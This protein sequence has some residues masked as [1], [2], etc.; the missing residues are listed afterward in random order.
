MELIRKDNRLK[1]ILPMFLACLLLLASIATTHASTV[2]GASSTSFSMSHGKA[3]L[4]GVTWSKWKST[5][6]NTAYCLE[7]GLKWS[8]NNN[9]FTEVGAIN[10]DRVRF[11]LTYGYPTNS[12]SNLKSLAG[13][14]GSLTKSEAQAATQY[15]LW[16]V[17]YGNGKRVNLDDLGTSGS[18]GKRVLKAAKYLYSESTNASSYSLMDF[19]YYSNGSASYQK[20]IIADGEPSSS[21]TVIK[22][23]NPDYAR[24]I[25]ADGMKDKEDG[26]VYYG[27]LKEAKFQIYYG[28]TKA[29]AENAA[30]DGDKSA[31]LGTYGISKGTLADAVSYNEDIESSGIDDYFTDKQLQRLKANGINS[32]DDT[33]YYLSLDDEDVNGDMDPG[34]YTL[35]ET[36][37]PTGYKERSM[38]TVEVENGEDAI[39]TFSNDPI[40]ARIDLTKVSANTDIT[41]GNDCYSLSGAKY[42]VKDVNDGDKTVDT[43]TTDSNGKGST[44]KKIPLGRY[45]VKETDASKGY[46]TDKTSHHV[47][48]TEDNYKSTETIAIGTVTSKEIPKNDPVDIFMVK[49]D[50]ELQRTVTQGAASFGGAEYTV[51]YYDN[52]YNTSDEAKA[53]GNKT[54]EWIFKTDADGVIKL[55]NE[56]TKYFV[57]GDPL[58]Y[59]TYDEACLPI[60][61]YLIQET[62]TPPGYLIDES[63]HVRQVTEDLDADIES[64][65]T[66]ATATSIEVVKRGDIEFK[67]IGDGDS[68][69][70]ANVPFEITSHTTGETHVIMTDINGYAST[71]AKWNSHLQNTNRGESAEDGVWFSLN[72]DKGVYLDKSAPDD[73]RGALLFDTYTLKELRCES[74]EGYDLITLD[75]TVYKDNDVIDLGTL[76]NDMPDLKTTATDKETG[77]KNVIKDNQATIIDTVSYTDLT[78]GKEYTVAGILTNKTTGEQ[79]I[80]TYKAID[81]DGNEFMTYGGVTASKTFTPSK[82]SGKVEVEFVFDATVLNAGDDVV[83]FED[84]YRDNEL[85][86]THSDINDK[87]QTVKIVEPE[88]KTTATNEDGGK[89]IEA[90]KDVK[91]I[92]TVT[93]K[94]LKPGE[95]YTLTGT[96]MDKKTNSPLLISG[97]EVTAQ[98]IFTPKESSGSVEVEFI[99]DATG[100]EGQELVVF[101]YLY[102]DNDLVTTHTD[103]EDKGQTVRVAKEDED[104]DKGKMDLGIND[105]DGYEDD[106]YG[107]SPQTSDKFPIFIIIALILISLSGLYFAHRRRKTN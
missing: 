91:I 28:T 88:I 54:R 102:K 10:N 33:V 7:K 89:L 94:N 39:T 42:S 107:G 55:S 90:T 1:R 72:H 84:L 74:N 35:K 73:L 77:S 16:A 58:Y 62:K 37:I 71:N 24:V 96:L 46:A 53:S 79:V 17:G 60:G 57:S 92:D 22:L 45:A 67:K 50:S 48:I 13:I 78:P 52:F 81:A 64:V 29:K 63:V 6:G 21:L 106:G 32:W 82:T 69:R 11:I 65:Y 38:Y 5:N 104:T 61:T 2:Y 9:S 59:D 95:T 70:L 26:T 87:D 40:M 14:S 34:Y 80:S 93:Y 85:L 44:T 98:A 31:R 30:E 103:I 19:K 100:L 3:Y 36:K 86:T 66:Y 18:A 76:T 12:V 51:T 99:F 4:S 83:V 49:W 43:I 68:K 15:A 27:S 97:K 8:R 23:I 75:F 105:D 56:A 47:K 101:E 25:D 41:N 20:M